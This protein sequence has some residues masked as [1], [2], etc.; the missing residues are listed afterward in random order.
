MQFDVVDHGVLL[1]GKWVELIHHVVEELDRVNRGEVELSKGPSASPR[2]DD[3]ALDSLS[4]SLASWH[5][6]ARGDGLHLY[7]SVR[8]ELMSVCQTGKRERAH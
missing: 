7:L 4:L 5:S 6:R 3:S 8:L 1:S 2:A